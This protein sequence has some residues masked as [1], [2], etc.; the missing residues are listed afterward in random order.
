MQSCFP[1]SGPT[2]CLKLTSPPGFVCLFVVL[3]GN[4]ERKLCVYNQQN[5]LWWV[6]S[7]QKTTKYQHLHVLHPEYRRLDGEAMECRLCK[8]CG[9]MLI[10]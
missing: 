9:C 10:T 6:R 1:A 8:Y 2:G 7:G 4:V 3:G 5:A